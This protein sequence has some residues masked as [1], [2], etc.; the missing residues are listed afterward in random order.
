MLDSTDHATNGR[1]I[2]QGAD[3]VHLVEAQTNQRCALD[4]RTANRRA[5]LFDRDRLCF[6]LL[7]SLGMDQTPL[8]LQTRCRKRRGEPEAWRT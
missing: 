8:I 7:R 2:F 5:D 6:S 4:S 1:R 3:P